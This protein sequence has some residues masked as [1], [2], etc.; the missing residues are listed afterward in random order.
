MTL[1]TLP[2]VFRMVDQCAVTTSAKVIVNGD[3]LFTV[4]NGPIEILSLQSVC[5]TA[6]DTT[7][8]TLQ[9]RHDPTDGASTTISGA[10][11]SLASAA[12]GATVT[13]QGTALSTVPTL[14][15][16]GACLGATRGIVV[17]SGTIEAV[18]GTGSTTGTWKHYIR[19]RPLSPTATVT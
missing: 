6:N 11:S 4:A 10:S 17:Q 1:P 7:A 13:L 5:I 2:R 8:S 19:Y 18:V 12:A 16:N 9:Y 15:A 3:V 14:T